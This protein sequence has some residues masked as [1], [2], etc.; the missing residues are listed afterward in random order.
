MSTLADHATIRK[1]RNA[2]KVYRAT[3]R[4]EAG[5]LAKIDG[6]ILFFSDTGAIVSIEP[7]DCVW[8][9]VLGEI[10]LSD[11]QA[12]MDHLHGGAAW[13]ATHRAQEAA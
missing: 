13:I 10:G 6:E 5:T 11:T 4:D 9:C 3:L 12:L 7:D 2:R 1:S 8:L